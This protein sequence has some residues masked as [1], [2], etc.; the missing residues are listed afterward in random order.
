MKL[1]TALSSLTAMA[2]TVISCGT[3]TNK[4]FWSASEGNFYF[5][6]VKADRYIGTNFWYGPLLAA[7]T[8]TGNQDR[9]AL[10]LDSLKS[11]GVT[12][13]RVLV[14]GDGNE[15]VRYKIEPLLQTAPGV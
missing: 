12:N 15:G 4:G 3:D 6:G 11:M 14:G 8:D 2:L 1:I 5:N 9:L 10:E 7:D 13:L